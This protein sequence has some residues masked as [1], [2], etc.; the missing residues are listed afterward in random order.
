LAI[1]KPNDL[2]VEKLQYELK[3]IKSERD[4]YRRDNDSLRNESM[5]LMETLDDLTSNVDYW[6]EKSIKSGVV[7]RLKNVLTQLRQMGE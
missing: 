6:S 1:R 4:Q 3:A 7:F 2:T 5:M